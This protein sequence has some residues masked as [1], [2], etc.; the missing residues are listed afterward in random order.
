MRWGLPWRQNAKMRPKPCPTAHVV[1][2]H[3]KKPPKAKTPHRPKPLRGMRFHNGR[4]WSR[5]NDLLL[6][7]A[8]GYG[9][10][11]AEF[12]GLLR[13]FIRPNRNSSRK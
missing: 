6:V 7:K 13:I 12:A 3:G 9:L 4:Y 1:Q 11:P 5:T 2:T 10:I 8:F